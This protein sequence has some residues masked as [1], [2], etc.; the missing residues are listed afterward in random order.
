M[1][2]HFQSCTHGHWLQLYKKSV[3][4]FLRWPMLSLS[5]AGNVDIYDLEA[6]SFPNKKRLAPM[7]A[8][9]GPAL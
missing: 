1:N 6:C 2:V 9:A 4:V 3:R 7:I 5:H 8:I